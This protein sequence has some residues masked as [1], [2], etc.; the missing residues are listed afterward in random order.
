MK[1]FIT[2]IFFAHG[3]IILA[4]QDSINILFYNVENL[5]D[6]KDDSLKND[7]EF[8]PSSKKKMDKFEMEY[9]NEQY[10]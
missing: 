2:L 4:Q 7:N 8:L 1:F 5:F 3:N 10:C 6:S 9:K